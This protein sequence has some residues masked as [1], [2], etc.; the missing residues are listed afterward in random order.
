MNNWKNLR[1]LF[2]SILTVFTSCKKS[3]SGDQFDDPILN[4]QIEANNFFTITNTYGPNDPAS[5]AAAALFQLYLD[6]LPGRV[7]LMN[8]PSENSPVFTT[9]VTDSIIRTFFKKPPVP[10]LH[11]NNEFVDLDLKDELDI[12]SKRSVKVGTNHIV[13]DKGDYYEVRVKVKFF[14]FYSNTSFYITSYLLGDFEAKDYGGGVNFSTQ[15][16]PGV[17]ELSAGRLTF[18]IDLASARDSSRL[19]VRKGDPVIHHRVLLSADSMSFAPGLLLDT[20]NIFGRSYDAGDIFGLAET[21]LRFKLP[22]TPASDLAMKLYVATFIFK[23]EQSD[24]FFKLENSF[25]TQI[26]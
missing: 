8:I 18:S 2:L 19:V 7:F 20:I 23:N 16:L 6:Y 13:V 26:R 17:T 21:P 4:L 11:L 10:A 12:V 14:E 15:P 22:K 3:N 25:Q 9:G 5:G 24:E 1:I